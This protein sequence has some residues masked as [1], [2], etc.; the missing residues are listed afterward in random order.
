MY[1]INDSQQMIVDM[2]CLR[3]TAGWM[4]VVLSGSKAYFIVTCCRKTQLSGRH[5]I[6]GLLGLRVSVSFDL[7]V[8]MRTRSSCTAF[9]CRGQLFSV[10]SQSSGSSVSGG[11][12]GRPTADRGAG[13]LTARDW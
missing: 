9:S 12:P 10:T 1:T 6:L 13:E 3:E 5:Y 4:F 8:G 7:V 2:K 11:S